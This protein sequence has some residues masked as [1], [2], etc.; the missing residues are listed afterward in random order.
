V[1]KGLIDS[2]TQAP[3]PAPT[4][5]PS[6]LTYGNHAANIF[7]SGASDKAGNIYVVWS[8]NST[9]LNTVQGNGQPS[10]SFDVW[11]AASHDGGGNFYGPWKVSSGSGT[12]IF[13]WIA[14]GD[15]GMVDIA[16]YQSASVAPPLVAD[17]SNPGALTGGPNNMPGSA[18]WN[19]MFAQ[20]LNANSREPVFTVSQASDHIIHTGSISN[21]GTF[22]SSDRSLL[23]FFN[24][25]IGPDGVANIFNADNGTSG[26][27][28]NYIRQNTG[29]LALTNPSAVTCLPIPVPTSVVSRMTHGSAGDF[30]VNLPLPPN[31][32][33]RGVEPR[34]SPSLGAGNYT[35]VFTFP[36][37]LTSVASASVTGHDPAGGT[38][39]VCASGN[40]IGPT[41][42]QYTVNLCGV[43]DQQYITVT[44]H[45]V[46]DVT[47]NN[48]DV[49]SPQMGVLIGDVNASGRVDAADVSS[50]RQQTLQTVTTSNFRNDLNTS[51]R[52]DAADVS[53]ARQ[54][55]LHT[56]P[57]A[58]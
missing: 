50:V 9:R 14:A 55:T 30:D 35:L 16:F 33:P 49:V 1:F 20:S 26:L 53:L 54:D 34:S 38:G 7:P 25:A 28:I 43:S 32:S 24:V 18:T 8:T 27:H 44:L 52:I 29:P 2:P 47:G 57:S 4:I 6:A 45:T 48:G 36:N 39:T 51:G 23:D 11:F 58:P 56:L 17:P 21:G 46:L 40:G 10:T 5:P 42:N 13:P 3:S 31:A 37:N 19:V 22:G 41:P 12:A 15:A